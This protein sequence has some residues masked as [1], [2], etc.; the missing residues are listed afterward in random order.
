MRRNILSIKPNEIVINIPN[1]KLVIMMNEISTFDFQ[2]EKFDEIRQSKYGQDRPVVYLIQW[3]G[4]IYIGESINVYNRCK[5]HFDKPERRKLN[6]IHVVSDYEY[7]KSAALDIESWLIQYM[8]AD[9]TYVLQN[10]SAWLQNHSYFEREKYQAKFEILREKLQQMQMAKRDLKEIRNSDL[11]KYS[12]YKTL[13][14]EQ[15]DIV[16]EIIKKIMW[17]ESGTIMVHWKPWTWKTILWIYL[18]KLLLETEETS[19]LKI[20]LVVPMTSL[21]STIKKVF[22]SIKWLSGRMVIWPSDVVKEQYDILIVDESHRLKKR[23]NITNYKSFDDVNRKLWLDNSWHELD[24]IM[25]SSKHQILLYDENQSIRPSD[26]SPDIFKE[27]TKNEFT[28]TSQQRVE[29]WEIY[30][31]YID[32]IFNLTQENKIEVWDY[33]FK[34]FDSITEFKKAIINKNTEVKLSRIVA[35]YARPWASKKEKEAFDITIWSESFRRN[36]T[37]I[38][39]VN[40]PNAINE[41]WCIHTV[42]WY[43]LNYVWVIIW[44]EITYNPLTNQMEIKKDNYYDKNGKNWIE[45]PEELRRYIINIYKTLLTRW[46]KW[47]YMYVVDHDLRQYLSRFI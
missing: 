12:P 38:N 35:W 30:I 31:E 32:S 34:L 33:D 37:N 1:F 16:R 17:N 7:N 42:Q 43:D 13:T 36:S 46:I 8:A 2:K 27:L 39:R 26:I 40:S 44:D 29:W 20:W 9:W 23:K 47:T 4:E 45:D 18:F 5:Q 6:K 15:I 41:V 11:F 21:R 19:H 22:W 24:R 25:S 28:L 14:D 3:K 10:K